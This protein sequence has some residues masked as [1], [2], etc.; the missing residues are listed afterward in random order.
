MSQEKISSFRFIKRRIVKEI[1]DNEVLFSNIEDTIA[2]EDARAN[3]EWFVSKA[4]VCKFRYYILSIVTFICPT[5]SQIFI[6][7]PVESYVPKVIISIVLGIS[8]LAAAVLTM[9]DSRNKWDI[10]R[11]EAERI[12]S[13]LRKYNKAKESL[14]KERLLDELDESYNETHKQWKNTFRK[15]KDE[16]TREKNGSGKD[17]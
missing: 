6:Y 7:I 14:E 13:I 10:Y 4:V 8:S 2:K 9:L 15:R 5:I 17:K 12:K 11:S 16:E 1:S 3:F